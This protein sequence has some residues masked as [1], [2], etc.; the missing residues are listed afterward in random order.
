[1]TIKVYNTLTR[2]K[3]EFVPLQKGKVRMYVCGVTVYDYCHLGHARSLIAFDLIYRFLEYAGYDVTFVRNFT[4][5]DDKIINRAHE[6]KIDWKELTKKFIQAYHEDT[7][8]LGLKKPTYEPKATEHM[9]EMIVLI[10]GLEKKGLAYEVNHDVFYKVRNFNGYGKLSGKNIEDLQAGAR[11]DVMEAKKDPL[12]FALWKSAKPG[13]P[14]WQSPW[15]EGRPGWHIECSAMSMKYLTET[16]DIH[17]GG[18]DLIFPHHENEIAQSEGH[19]D[20][21]FAK[22]W[23]HNGFVNIN[24][25][26]MSKSLDNFITIRDILN[27]FPG[28][29]VRLFVLSAHY[30]SPLDYTDQNIFDA[31]SALE[32]FYGMKARLVD[33]ANFGK[34]TS[35]DLQEKI[36]NF[37]NDFFAAMNDDFNT[38][39]V[40]GQ[41]FE[42]VRILNKAMDNHEVSKK[43][44]QDFLTV[45]NDIAP[46]LG[47]F[48]SEATQFLS[49]T[50]A[51]K[52]S[53]SDV[54]EADI[55]KLIQERLD[56][57]K[58]RDFKRADQIRD[59]LKAKGIILK[60]NPDGSTGWTVG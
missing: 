41:I 57:R 52:L 28:E 17:G 38:A 47:V 21:H 59:E 18:R 48:G 56:A 54:S 12:D 39:K 22:Y 40:I 37:K 19:T 50:R 11:V 25:E 55:K 30:R 13:E 5:I 29:A 26:K 2:Q 43:S 20:K 31:V 6:Q 10:Q 16:F 9:N 3:E 44:A 42:F 15:G 1:M 36:D 51:K 23:L 45:L 53:S 32:R 7:E 33:E 27:K 46:V 35:K 4:D 14:S 34:M 60:D 8:K 24:A 58:N 49:D